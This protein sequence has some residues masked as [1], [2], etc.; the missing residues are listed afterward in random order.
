MFNQLFGPSIQLLVLDLFVENPDTLFNLREIAR[1]IDKNPGSVT[2][3]IPTL[4]EMDIVTQDKVGKVT[5]VYSLNTENEL[6]QILLEFYEKLKA[7]KV[8][9]KSKG[10]KIDVKKE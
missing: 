6:V 10:R 7:L 4:V 2:R 1:R 3:T 8:K 5:H 9:R